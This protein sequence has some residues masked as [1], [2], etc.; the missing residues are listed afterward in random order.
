[1]ASGAVFGRAG[2]F[3]RPRGV[4]GESDRRP[5]EGRRKTVCRGV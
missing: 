2:L 3:G 4:W 5:S 1:M